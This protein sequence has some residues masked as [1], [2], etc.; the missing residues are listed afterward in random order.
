MFIKNLGTSCLILFLNKT[1]EFQQFRFVFF[2]LDFDL[3]SPLRINLAI[4]DLISQEL[5]NVKLIVLEVLSVNEQAFSNFRS[6]AF[7]GF[8]SFSECITSIDHELEEILMSSDC[9]IVDISFWLRES[10]AS[11]EG[12]MFFIIFGEGK[13]VI[14]IG[15]LA[16][17]RADWID[18]DELEL[19]VSF[20]K[21]KSGV[22]VNIDKIDI[23]DFF[24]FMETVFE[25]ISVDH[26]FIGLF[27]FIDLFLHLVFEYFIHKSN[28][29]YVTFA[30]SVFLLLVKSFH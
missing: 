21:V 19:N 1:S 17:M 12:R 27:Y 9:S 10:A 30:F 11:H 29:F 6:L 28:T 25:H 5:K 4:F 20:D 18:E 2:V 14:Q 22:I 13:E 7:L 15:D 3:I 26:F 23:F 16:E 8:R 24:K